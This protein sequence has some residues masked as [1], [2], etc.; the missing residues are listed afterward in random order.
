MRGS[1]SFIRGA[2][3]DPSRKEATCPSAFA[4]SVSRGERFA[5]RRRSSFAAKHAAKFSKGEKQTTLWGDI[6]SESRQFLAVAFQQRRQQILG[7]GYRLK[8]DVASLVSRSSDSSLIW[9]FS[10]RLISV[11]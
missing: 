3:E 10:P 9:I 8:T 1:P 11:C 5:I 6:R 4:S 7:E 2:E